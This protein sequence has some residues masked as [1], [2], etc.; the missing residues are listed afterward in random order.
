MSDDGIPSADGR[1]DGSLGR[2]T[3][4]RDVLKIFRKYPEHVVTKKGRCGRGS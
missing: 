2:V 1:E 3:S 4:R